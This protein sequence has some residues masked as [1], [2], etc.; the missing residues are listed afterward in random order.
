MCLKKQSKNLFYWG[1]NEHNIASMDRID[2]NTIISVAAGD[3]FI[4]AWTGIP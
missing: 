1:D 3:G 4:I 2:G